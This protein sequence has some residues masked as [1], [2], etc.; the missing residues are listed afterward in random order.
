MQIKDLEKENQV[1]GFFAVKELMEKE[2]KSK[3]K[4]IDINLMDISGEINAKVWDIPQSL[5]GDRPIKGDIVKVDA[6]V[7]EYNKALQLRVSKIRK[8]TKED[9]YDLESL[10][11][12][13]PVD[14]SKMWG[15]LTRFISMIEDNAIKTTVSNIVE[16]NKQKLMRYP[17][18]KA[19]HHSIQG[20]LLHH[21]TTMLQ[22]AEKITTVYF[23]NTDI[24]YAGIILHDIGKIQELYLD[25]TGVAAEYTIEG[26]LLGHIAIGM[27]MLE[28]AADG[29][30]IEKK[31][32]LQH[33]ILSHHQ[34]PEWGSP[35]RPMTKEAEL[36]HHL[37]M[38]DS[39]CTILTKPCHK[40]E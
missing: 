1:I 30:D 36:L 24:L 6:I 27:R 10:I 5:K 9:N 26:E 14:S 4:Y 19:Y 31:L 2:T 33:L 38:I 18:A 28:E 29:L 22:A 37:D 39:G 35:K 32:I 16:K 12:S 13:A 20:G 8:A 7:D 21:I 11:P 3:K 23:V 34:I 17:A 40:L 25:E 15:I